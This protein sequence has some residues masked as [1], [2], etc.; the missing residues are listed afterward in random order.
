MHCLLEGLAHA[1]FC[2]FLGLTA[3]STHRK[4]D[5][6]SAF[7]D[8]S[9]DIDLNKPETF[10]EKDVRA[11]K[12]IQS[13]LTEAVPDLEGNDTELIERHVS[14]LERKLMSK[15][16]VYLQ[17]MSEG[18][19]IRPDIAHPGK[20][21]YKAHWV[22]SLIGWCQ[23]Q[24]FIPRLSKLH[25]ATP[26][27]MRCI[28]DVIWDT[29]KLSLLR[30]VPYDFGETKA[31]TM[32]ADE[33][34]TL[35]MVYLP[36]VLVLLLHASYHTNGHM[37]LHIWDY[38]QLFGPVWS[39]WCFPYERLISQLQHLPSNHI[40][41]TIP[42][43]LPKDMIPEELIWLIKVQ[44]AVLHARILH[45]G[46]TY[47]HDSTHVGNSLILYYPGG[48]KSMQPAPVLSDHL[49]IV[50]PEWVVSHFAWWNF[51]AQHIVAV[52]LCWD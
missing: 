9:F 21:V 24:P 6:I 5:T 48:V 38:L 13:L 8:P 27:V 2:E 29:D 17:F 11:V 30:S 25:I 35:T 20:K 42:T 34:H 12:S 32:K 50:M 18:L 37:A 14:K 43:S 3:D 16:V 15:K 26:E 49:E 19:G 40:F 51:S 45:N 7:D 10:T 52:S 33:W 44:W 31:G 28:A 22:K 39:W 41:G 47:T 1:H 46:S 23:T 36:I 4:S